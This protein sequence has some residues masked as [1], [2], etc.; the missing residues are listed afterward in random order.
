MVNKNEMALQSVAAQECR[1][2]LRIVHKRLPQELG[3]K[4]Y[5]YLF[6]RS[7][8]V[9]QVSNTLSINVGMA[10]IFRRNIWASVFL[11][12]CADVN[13]RQEMTIQYYHGGTFESN[14]SNH[15]QLAVFLNKDL[16]QGGILPKK[17]HPQVRRSRRC[18]QPESPL[19]RQ[20]WDNL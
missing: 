17:L 1:E 7:G 10:I 18:H 16:F 5:E 11:Q 4:V 9:N 13:I 8:S 6:P 19:G 20:V 15:G 12:E 2:L 3:D 14:G